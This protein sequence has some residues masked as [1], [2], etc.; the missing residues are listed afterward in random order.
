MT[1]MVRQTGNM[2]RILAL[3][4]FVGLTQVG[5]FA[6]SGCS[7]SL[8]CAGPRRNGL[9]QSMVSDKEE[10]AIAEDDEILPDVDFFAM[11][12]DDD[13]DDDDDDEYDEDDEQVQGDV[14]L[15]SDEWE[16][17]IEPAAPV[18]QTEPWKKN[19][20]WESLNPRVKL[21]IIEAQQAKAIENKKKREP[22]ADKK[23]RLL[24]RYKTLQQEKK[25]ASRVKRPLPLDGRTPLSALSPDMEVS[26]TVISFAKF[27]AYIDV[28]TE[29]DGLLHI[30]QISETDFI[31]HP[32]Q[33]MT[34]GEEIVVRVKWV[35]ADLKKL[36]LTM[37]P[38]KANAEQEDFDEES[39]MDRIPLEDVD[40]DDELWG[41]IKRVTA[42]GAYVELGAEVDGFLHFMDHPQF[43]AK[44]G[45]PPKDFMAVGDRVRVWVSDV[46]TERERIKLTANRPDALPG[47]RL[48]LRR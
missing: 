28:G 48:E 43:N 16:N 29:C 26:G 22:I 41:E 35:D 32:R 8:T 7:R 4:A 30:S 20:R 39:D 2:R 5:A 44:P 6:P 34:P 1:S 9:M 46:D 13:D 37:L 21:R 14:T 11:I 19:A 10:R 38:L 17:G 25:K 12:D 3:A 36:Q 47:P 23:R 45:S 24:F 27:G 31:E 15:Y 40:A 33:V 42:Y 18:P